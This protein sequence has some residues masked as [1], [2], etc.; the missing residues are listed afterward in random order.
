MTRQPGTAHTS[1]GAP[2]RSKDSP[3]QAGRGRACSFEGC[4]TIL[5]TYNTAAS[6]W[7]HTQPSM[8][9]PLSTR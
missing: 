1:F 3:T 2:T 7:L 4:T 8:R 9:P 6:C 5:S